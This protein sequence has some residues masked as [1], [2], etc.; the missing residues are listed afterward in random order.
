MGGWYLTHY[1]LSYFYEYDDD[2]ANAC[3]PSCKQ[4]IQNVLIF[5]NLLIKCRQHARHVG[6][7]TYVPLSSQSPLYFTC[8]YMIHRASP[9]R[10]SGHDGS[11]FKYYQS[12]LHDSTFVFSSSLQQMNFC[13]VHAGCKRQIREFLVCTCILLVHTDI[14]ALHEN[15]SPLPHDAQMH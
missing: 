14:S 5:C 4:R 1:S 6:E 2:D 3:L 12:S 7:P 11:T 9:I 13:F 15:N 10:R 8:T